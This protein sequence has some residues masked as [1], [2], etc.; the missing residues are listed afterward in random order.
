MAIRALVVLAVA[1][2]A[3]VTAVTRGGQ[4]TYQN[5]QN[6]RNSQNF[7]TF[8]NSRNSQNFQPFQNSRNSQNFQTF[9][10]SRNSQNFQTFQNSQ[11]SQNSR[12]FQNSR[13]FQNSQTQNLGGGRRLPRQVSVIQVQL[14]TTVTYIVSPITSSLSQYVVSNPSGVTAASQRATQRERNQSQQALFFQSL[15][16]DR[17]RSRSTTGLHTIFIGTK[18]ISRDLMDDTNL[19]NFLLEEIF[20]TLGFPT[21]PTQVLQQDVLVFNK[22]GSP[23]SSRPPVSTLASSP[24]SA[25][26]PGTLGGSSSSFSSS[27]SSS[28]TGAHHPPLRCQNSL[29][30]TCDQSARFRTQDGTCN[31][32]RFNQ[33]GASFVPLRRFLPPAYDDGRSRPRTVSRAG[34]PLPS[35]RLVSIRIHPDGPE[36]QITSLTHMVMQW[37]QFTDHDLTSTA[38]QTAADGSG[39]TCCEDDIPRKSKG[40]VHVSNRTACFPIPIPS[41]DPFFTDRCCLGFTRSVQVT[42]AKCQQSPVEQINQITSYLDASQ[43]YGSTDDENRVLRTFRQGQLRTSQRDLLPRDPKET[44]RV[45]NPRDFC[46]KAGDERVNEQMAL[47]SLHTVFLRHH[48]RLAQRLSQIN[49]QWGDERLFQETRKIVGAHIQK[50]TYGDWL[51][52]V[53]DGRR[54]QRKGL[55]L[56]RS[57]QRNVYRP[58]VDPT[59]RNVFST[60]AFRFGHSLIRTTLSQMGANYQERGRWRLEQSFG[61]TSHLL[62]SQG[63]GVA[64]YMRGLLRDPPNRVDRFFTGAVRDRLFLDGRGQSL[65]LVA[66]NIQRGRDHGLPG[67]NAWRRFCGLGPVTFNSMPDHDPPLARQ[68]AQIYRHPDDIDVFSGAISERAEGG[69]LVGPTFACIIA[70]QFNR[71]KYGDRF[72]FETNDPVTG[73]TPAQVEEIRKQTLSRILCDVTNIRTI[74]P[75]PFRQVSNR[76]P[77]VNCEELAEMDLGPWQEGGRSGGA[78]WSSWGP[79]TRCLSGLQ[80]RQRTCSQGGYGG[81][82]S[83]PGREARNCGDPAWTSGQWTAWAACRGPYQTRSRMCQGSTQRCPPGPGHQRRLCRGGSGMPPS[84]HS[85][86]GWASWGPWSRGCVGGKQWRRRTCSTPPRANGMGPVGA[87]SGPSTQARGCGASRA[88]WAGGDGQRRWV[89]AYYKVPKLC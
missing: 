9:Q 87:C 13:T 83:G 63:L 15:G 3:A 68:F 33:W 78:S 12:N 70:E 79:W 49:P 8:Q 42:N 52:I 76:N 74:Q 29:N 35:A 7:Q 82:C 65:D 11:N 62:D 27:F 66:L 84:W 53:L 48:N 40:L 89:C 17:Q 37:G 21:V 2:M 25:L 72:W 71:V 24:P 77:L 44:C 28:S 85:P 18:S 34:G 41:N 81:P 23:T 59:I 69:G 14:T 31:N 16:L 26:S 30:L 67:Y 86:T 57:G 20:T 51:P 60:A 61:N 80:T 75:N 45:D 46:F 58:Q 88:S 73:L 32:L 38:V 10:N 22:Q 54:L 1:H 36:G 5:F 6:S 43:V 39:L 55:S 47:S 64:R 50:I 56:L 19:V 4:Q